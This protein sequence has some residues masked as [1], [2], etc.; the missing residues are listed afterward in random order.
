IASE[1]KA[2]LK[3]RAKLKKRSSSDKSNSAEV[4]AR[5]QIRGEETSA[6]DINSLFSEKNIKKSILASIILDKPKF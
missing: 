2:N 6:F 5:G 4:D 3:S 1:R